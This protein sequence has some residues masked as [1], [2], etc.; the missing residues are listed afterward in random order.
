M[1]TKISVIRR[2][3]HFQIYRTGSPSGMT[4]V[5]YQSVQTR[6]MIHIDQM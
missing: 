4:I 3:F 5:G 1:Q 6:G 2:I